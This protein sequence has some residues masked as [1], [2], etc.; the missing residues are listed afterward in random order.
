MKIKSVIYFLILISL[1]AC[2][3]E[4]DKAT[5]S[6][7]SGKV[8]LYDDGNVNLDNI[9][10]T[11]TVEGTA[12][13]LSA[14]TD[15]NGEYSIQDVPF[16]SYTLQFN[17]TGYGT[18][19]I[20]DATLISTG[21]PLVISETV[22]L[23]QISTTSIINKFLI[24]VIQSTVE[25]RGTVDPAGTTEIPR[26]LRLFYSSNENVSSDNYSYYSDQYVVS[27]DL[28]QIIVTKEELNNMGFASG[29][30]VYLKV[31]GDSY[32]SNSYEDPSSNKMVFPN[33]NSS[34]ES[35]SFIV[36]E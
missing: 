14:K 35:G 1:V 30:T 25:F 36:P 28:F 11:V 2:K 13:L 26:Y 5:T 15:Q 10:M 17:K 3:K 8:K 20:F 6:S 18:Y 7:I 19:K 12:P 23:G 32:W 33:L 4:E 22:S 29:T 16:G 31:Y 9:D 34:P 21:G 27:E 24:N